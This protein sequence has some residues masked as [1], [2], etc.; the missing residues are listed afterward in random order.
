MNARLNGID[1]VSFAE[2][3]FFEPVA[4]EKF[5]LIV[6]NPPF[7]ISP[8]SGLMFQNAELAGDQ[9]SE[10]ILRESP[11]YLREGAFAVSLIS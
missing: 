6:T 3:S 11:A 1:N 9:V 7:I 8:Q 10:L 2:G 4:S 5:D